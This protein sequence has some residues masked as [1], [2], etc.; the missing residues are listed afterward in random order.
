ML[1]IRGQKIDRGWLVI[2]ELSRLWRPIS[3]G[4]DC[5]TELAGT[6]KNGSPRQ[7]CGEVINAESSPQHTGPFTLIFHCFFIQARS[8][9]SK[10]S[11][12]CDVLTVLISF[13]WG[14]F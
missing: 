14:V 4:W 2:G 6:L 8:R 10:F 11:F 13:V 3:V 7:R 1:C 9:Y 5:S 12:G